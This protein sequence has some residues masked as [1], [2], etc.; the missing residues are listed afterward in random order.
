MLTAAGQRRLDAEWAS[1]A[2][3]EV[4]SGVTVR[5][6]DGRDDQW[7]FTFPGPDGTPYQG[8]VF[9][10]E[11]TWPSNYPFEPPAVRLLTPIFHPN[12]YS[13]G[14]PGLSILQADDDSGS[15]E[16]WSISQT[17]RTVMQALI[18]LVKEPD[19]LRPANVDAARLYTSDS[20]AYASK[21]AEYT[22]Q[23][24]KPRT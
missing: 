3:E 4:G 24:A 12:I 11:F 19:A 17:A 13:G 21:A 22:A 18:A 7:V 14:A 15:D 10:A 9:E 16:H 1:L 23:Y 8:G 6:V 20:K 2:A 5:K